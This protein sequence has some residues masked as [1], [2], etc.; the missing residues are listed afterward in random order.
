MKAFKLII[1]MKSYKIKFSKE[2]LK[3]NLALMTH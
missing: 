3:K 2:N 1:K